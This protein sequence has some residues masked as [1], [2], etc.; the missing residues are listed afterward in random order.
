MHIACAASG[1]LPA[2]LAASLA[3]MVEQNAI[4]SGLSQSE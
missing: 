3:G 1:R 2:A 4:R